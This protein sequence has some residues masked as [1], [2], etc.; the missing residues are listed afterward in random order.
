MNHPFFRA[1]SRKG[2]AWSVAKRLRQATHKYVAPPPPPPPRE[3]PLRSPA[4]LPFLPIVAK[5]LLFFPC[6]CLHARNHGTQLSSRRYRRRPCGGISKT[7]SRLSS[8]FTRWG[9][10]LHPAGHE[11]GETSLERRRC[12][13]PPRPLLMR[14]NCSS[15]SGA[16]PVLFF[17]GIRF[18][19]ASFISRRPR[20]RGGEG[21][22]FFFFFRMD[23]QNPRQAGGPAK[24][25]TQGIFPK[26]Y[27]SCAWQEVE[28]YRI[29]HAH[30]S[31]STLGFL[32][33]VL[34]W[35]VVKAVQVI[36][37]PLKKIV[38]RYRT[39]TT[40]ATTFAELRTLDKPT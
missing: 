14:W 25:A 36:K 38:H 19:L 7:V 35:G 5:P 6:R 29:G 9:F 20:F 24:K 16:H 40:I 22:G 30:S 31:D 39:V 28:L 37:S 2:C 17:L 18:F 21:V 23:R 8:T 13:T 1:S 4:R 3:L 33:N 11:A 26:L 12:G 34:V 32:Q 15:F 27:S 10:F